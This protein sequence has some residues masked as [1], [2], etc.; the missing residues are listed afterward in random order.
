MTHET[1]KVKTEIFEGPLDLLL[2]LIE[3]RKLFIND[4]SLAKVTDDYIEYVRSLHAFPVSDTANF[5]LIA[6][7]LVLIKSKSLLPNLSLTSE[8][9][10]NIEDLE[11]RLQLYKTIKE[12][13]VGIK[14]MFGKNVIFAPSMNRPAMV[15]FSPSKDLSAASLAEAMERVINALPKRE[16]AL[17]KVAVKA[18]MSLE[19]MIDHLSSRIQESL[20]MSFNSFSKRDTSD[21]IHVIISFLAVLELV[22]RGAVSII[23]EESFSDITIETHEIATPKYF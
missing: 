3:K 2:S 5:V 11:L 10:T 16:K 22:K 20:K 12:L 23:Q 13:G 1:Y 7:T 18:A 21:K 6:A 19:E 8:E 17:P 4:I 9:Q 14:E 15:V